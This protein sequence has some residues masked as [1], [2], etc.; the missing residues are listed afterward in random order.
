MN[1]V[2]VIRFFEK[3]RNSVPNNVFAVDKVD[4]LPYRD[5]FVIQLFEK[6]CT[7]V[8]NNIAVEDGEDSLTYCQLNAKVSLLAKI[9]MEHHCR[10][11]QIIPIVT[12]SCISMIT[13]ILAI[14]K[15]GAAYV[16]IDRSQ[17][18]FHRI[19][20]V[21]RRIGS[22]VILYTGE[23]FCFGD[24]LTIR[25]DLRYNGYEQYLRKPL[26]TTIQSELACVIFTSGT[27]NEPKGVMIRNTSL[28]HFVSCAPFNYDITPEDR[29]LLV[30]S[31]AFDG[32][33]ARKLFWQENNQYS[34]Y[35]NLVQ[36]SL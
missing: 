15:V 36:H 12:S 8:P 33:F 31:I 16:P 10:A 19:Q 24:T 20:S 1:S 6:M 23:S 34:M 29:V 17:W 3:I 21:L 18:P 5:S 4:R 14:L 25:A 9:L 28:A 27:T 32:M 30:M 2:F 11:E 35:G 13:G 26:I 22:P 7:S